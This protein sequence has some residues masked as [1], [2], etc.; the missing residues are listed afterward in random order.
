MSRCT[1]AGFGTYMGREKVAGEWADHFSC[2]LTF[3]S[4]KDEK[5]VFQSWNALGLGKVARG[6]ELRVTGGDNHPS[7]NTGTPR[8]QT[9]LYSNF[10]PWAVDPAA[11]DHPKFCI[12]VGG[13]KLPKSQAEL[14]SL[15]GIDGPLTVAHMHHESIRHRAAYVA[16]DLVSASAADLTRATRPKPGAHAKG[17]T[18][19]SAMA[20]LNRQLLREAQLTTRPCDEWSVSELHAVQREL[21]AARSFDMQEV[22]DKAADRRALPYQDGEALA[23]AHSEQ[24]GGLRQATLPFVRDGLC[25]ET[26]MMY[27]HHLADSARREL[28]AGGFVLPLLPERELYDTPTDSELSSCPLARKMHADYVAKASCAICH[29][30]QR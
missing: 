30:E 11:F 22:Y 17:D 5:L 13:A 14:S 6:T 20:L 27:I 25:K 7:K 1:A 18:V 28:K 23:A 15:F 19:S 16:A 21:L 29:V 8:L 26:V 3:P 10:T 9:N 2:N 4:K 12:P 24:R